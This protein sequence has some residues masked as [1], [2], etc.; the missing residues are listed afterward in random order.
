[1]IWNYFVTGHGKGEV[2]DT[3]A[4][5]KRKFRKEQIKPNV[6]KLQ[7][8]GDVVKYLREEATRRHVVYPSIR[9]ITSKYFWE[10][11]KHDINR[12]QLYECQTIHGSHKAHQVQS[13]SHQDLTLIEY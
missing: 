1:M 5:L 13:I 12:N 6:C 10:V 3:G 9:K 2:D 4:L 7:C 11:T 8:A